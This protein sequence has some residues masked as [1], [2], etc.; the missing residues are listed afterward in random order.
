MKI[1]TGL[2]ILLA[3]A[4]ASVPACGKKSKKGKDDDGEKG[5]KGDKAKNAP[6][7]DM[8]KKT[9]KIGTLDAATGPVAVIGIPFRNGKR[10]VRDVVNAGGSDL[11]PE[12]WK[13]ELSEED[14]AYDGA[15]AMKDYKS[16]KDKVLFI[17]TSFGT[18]PTQAIWEE[19]PTDNMLAFPASLS[20]EMAG[21]KH[22]PP[23][24]ASYKVEAE[25][26]MEW[27]VEHAKGAANVKAG[28]IFQDD[29]YGR[30]ALAG[31][32]DQAGQLSVDVVAEQSVTPGQPDVTA[33][34][35]ALKDGGANYVMLATL[36]SSTGP[37]LGTA[38]KLQ[39][40]P[41]WIGNT[42]AWVDAFFSHDKLPSAVF[43]NF[44]WVTGLPY[45]GED[46]PGMDKFVKAFEAHG[47]DMKAD[48]Y[49]LASYIQGLIQME[50]LKRAIN[51]GDVSR[52]GI[53]SAMQSITKWDAGGLIKPIDLSKMPYVTS[54]E[55]HVLKPDFENKTW[56]EVAPYRTPGAPSAEGDNK[57]PEEPE[58]KQGG[59]GGGGT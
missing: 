9:V 47:G 40:M 42:P 12:G 1:K 49:V 59:A 48:F 5:G 7:V 13:I 54:T 8:A 18:P 39:Y 38:A 36:P 50:I 58:E 19:F 20:S 11:L 44:Y 57:Q 34:I 56:S 16:I 25:R 33:A 4:L 55:T 2:S 52:A 23:L 31:W 37:V 10:L 43:T 24:G 46:V 29:D 53:I 41:V 28:I 14:H 32:K 22:T 21:N 27:A 30:D 3:L 45:W 51:N 26:A 6:G 17:G 15:E 35:K